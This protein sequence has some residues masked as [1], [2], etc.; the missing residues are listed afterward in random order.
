MMKRADDALAAANNNQPGD[1][2]KFVQFLADYV[3]REGP[4]EGKELPIGLPVGKDTWNAVLQTTKDK[5]A[6]LEAFKDVIQGTD[7]D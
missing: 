3:R 1:P 2:Q 4:F 5:Q 6:D 7:L